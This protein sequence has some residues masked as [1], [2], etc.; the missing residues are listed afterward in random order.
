M[1]LKTRATLL[2][3]VIL[4]LAALGCSSG[5]SSS[6]DAGG[7]SATTAAGASTTAGAKAAAAIDP[8]SLLSSAQVGTALS[9]PVGPPTTIKVTPI[10]PNGSA[11]NWEATAKQGELIF[12]TA[13]VDL[14]NWS[15]LPADWTAKNPSPTTYASRICEN[16][17][18]AATKVDIPG[19]VACRTEFL[20]YVANDKYLAIVGVPNLAQSPEAETASV[21]LAKDVAAKL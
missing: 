7:G 6:S 18:A 4:S 10:P 5:G 20:T 3:V 1:N 12:R 13:R 14:W 21:Q 9:R 19:F 16:K 8:C 11:C 15:T 17:D 2:C